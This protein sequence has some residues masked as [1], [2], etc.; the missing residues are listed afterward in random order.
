MEG[1]GHRTALVDLGA[2]SGE[3]LKNWLYRGG[4]L[5][6]AES[7]NLGLTVIYVLGDAVD[8][9]GHLK[10]C[11]GALGP[12]VRYVV[13]KNKGVASKFDIYDQ[14]NIR[15]EVLNV[16]GREIIFP[17]L[18]PSVYQSVDRVSASFSDFAENRNGSSGFTE[19]RY[20]RTWLRD[21]FSAL[22]QVGS[23]L[24]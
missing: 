17:A 16:G 13:V 10:E 22:D 12:S 6:E 11:F 3:D 21:C 8:S 20:C 23:F 1:V 19:R 5:D 4:A 15:R 7:G 2:R 14:S 24:R 9:V 18:D